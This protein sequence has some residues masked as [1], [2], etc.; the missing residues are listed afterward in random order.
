MMWFF[1]ETLFSGNVH[2]SRR[3]QHDMYHDMPTNLDHV[4]ISF[5]IA[6]MHPG[7]TQLGKLA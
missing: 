3:L 5:H 4:Y 6:R 1:L 2:V 7:P